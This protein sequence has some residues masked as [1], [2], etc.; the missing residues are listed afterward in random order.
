MF[1]LKR[2]VW[3]KLLNK[4]NHRTSCELKWNGVSVMVHNA[5]FNNI[6]VISWRSALLAEETWRKPPT[7]RRVTDKLYHIMLYRVH[8]AWTEFELKTLVVIGSDCIGSCNSRPR[9]PPLNGIIHTKLKL[10]QKKCTWEKYN[11]YI[12]V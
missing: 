12:H 9:W 2:I 11:M 5:T 6:S 7:C 8:L 10:S 1:R 4:K 3:S